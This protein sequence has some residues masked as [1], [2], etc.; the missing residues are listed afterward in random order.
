[1]L[2]RF[3]KPAEI[4][5]IVEHV[6][7]GKVDVLIGTHRILSQDIVFDRLGLVVDEEHRF[8]VR[9]KERIK[10]LKHEVNVLTLT[11]TPIPRT[12]H[13][14]TVGMRDL[15]TIQTPPAVRSEIKTE[16]L[17]FDEE[18]IREAIV[19]ELHR[20]GQV[21]FVYN[22]VASIHSMAQNIR[23][24]VSMPALALPMADEGPTRKIMVEFV[25]RKPTF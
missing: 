11:A 6:R 12:L 24:W 17:R 16:V 8:G 5:T 10:E 9:H 23:E 14:A 13:M 1:M 2:N 21:F 7:E 18:V 19:R 15:S 3:R 20:G 25:T 22:R 4:K